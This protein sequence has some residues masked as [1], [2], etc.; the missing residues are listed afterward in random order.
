MVVG[1]HATRT[2]FPGEVAH[3]RSWISKAFSDAVYAPG[4]DLRM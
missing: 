1:G 4:L 2:F 3:E